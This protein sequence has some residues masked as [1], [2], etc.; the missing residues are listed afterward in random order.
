M[1]TT[2]C[3]LG[4]PHVQW[5]GSFPPPNISCPSS[6]PTPNKN[7]GI[8]TALFLTHFTCLFITAFLLQ[9]PK[10]DEGGSKE[11]TIQI[12][13]DIQIQWT[14]LP[15][16][17]KKCLIQPR[18][19]RNPDKLLS[20]GVDESCNVEK[21]VGV[22]TNQESNP[23]LQGM[24]TS[25]RQDNYNKT[26]S[27][28]S[29]DGHAYQESAKSSNSDVLV[30]Q[31]DNMK[32]PTVTNSS[33]DILKSTSSNSAKPSASIYG[34]EK[35]QESNQCAMKSFKH[36][37]VII[38]ESVKNSTFK[39]ITP[40]QKSESSERD[41]ETT[42]TYGS[43]KTKNFGKQFVPFSPHGSNKNNKTL[44]NKS[45]LS[46]SITLKTGTNTKQRQ[47]QFQ[48]GGQT[49]S[50]FSKAPTRLLSNPKTSYT[51]K[52]PQ[53]PF[54]A[55]VQPSKIVESS[56]IQ[57]PNPKMGDENRKQE[58]V[59]STSE[60][61][62]LTVEEDDPLGGLTDEDLI[63]ILSSDDELEEEEI[64]MVKSVPPAKKNPT[65]KSHTSGG[66]TKKPSSQGG[67]SSQN[68]IKQNKASTQKKPA[69]KAPSRTIFDYAKAMPSGSMSSSSHQKGQKNQRNVAEVQR[70]HQ[71]TSVSNYGG[72]SSSGSLK[73]NDK[74]EEESGL[75]CCPLCQLVF[76]AR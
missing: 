34:S 57:T 16:Y 36:S 66:K 48:A 17:C 75:Q 69:S 67:K 74:L 65:W 50:K 1:C 15:P 52:Q 60:N 54:Q 58:N 25:G 71:E 5:K 7:A 6:L 59:T 11:I 30:K 70:T 40:G 45:I 31:T 8:T 38:Q 42:K 53:V 56:T 63:V 33:S 3:N 35:F 14:P 47:T 13:E 76:E 43:S 32:T 37:P 24:E 64:K 22:P 44:K 55:G 21:D 29:K 19:K 27:N 73:K 72:Q 18:P 4:C 62:S 10:S 23:S 41:N 68:R 2:Q 51:S 61:T 39:K 12:T 9:N 46:E 20:E 28:L 49:P 26:F